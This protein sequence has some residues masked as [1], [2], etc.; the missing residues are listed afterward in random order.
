M[1]WLRSFC[2][3]DPPEFGHFGA[4]ERDLDLA[5]PHG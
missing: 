3:D 2:V 5:L 4:E 1:T